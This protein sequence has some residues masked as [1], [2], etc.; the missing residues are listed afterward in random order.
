MNPCESHH[1]AC[2]CREDMF[3]I[4]KERAEFIES[5]NQRLR[6]RIESLLIALRGA[7]RI[8]YENLPK[9]AGRQ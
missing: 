1:F 7:E 2:Q 4:I 8:I 9:L 6:E 3:R 5:E